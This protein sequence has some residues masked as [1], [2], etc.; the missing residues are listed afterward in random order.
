MMLVPRGGFMMRKRHILVGMILSAITLAACHGQDTYKQE[1]ER[2]TGLLGWHA[3]SA[4]A[5]IGAGDGEMTLLAAERVGPTGRVYA[6]EI[7]SQ[8]L[9]KLERLSGEHPNITA[10]KAA[11]DATN[12]PPACCD[13]IVVRRVYHHFPKPAA[14]A[15]SLLRSLKP[16]GMLAVIDFAPRSGYP[17]V[18][19]HVPTNRGGHGVAQKIVIDELTAAGFELVS[20]SEDWPEDDYGV[21]FRRPGRSP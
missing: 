3:G 10:V 17:E 4:V 18:K 9:E 5:D 16:G 7:D 20:L 13:S 14:M 6:T 8:K 15:A 2:L 1:A 21:I 12:L 11:A 19:E